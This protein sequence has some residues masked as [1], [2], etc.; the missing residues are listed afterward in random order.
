MPF[1]KPVEMHT[2]IIKTAFSDCGEPQPCFP[3]RTRPSFHFQMQAGWGQCC[4]FLHRSRSGCE[5][6]FQNRAS[7]FSIFGRR[8]FG[9]S[10]IIFFLKASKWRLKPWAWAPAGLCRAG[11][12]GVLWLCWGWC[13]TGASLWGTLGIIAFFLIEQNYCL[14]LLVSQVGMLSP[15]RMSFKKFFPPL[16]SHFAGHRVKLRGNCQLVFSENQT[17]AFN[18]S[19][20]NAGPQS[21]LAVR[22]HGLVGWQRAWELRGCESYSFSS[23]PSVKPSGSVKNF[24]SH[25]YREEPDKGGG[26]EW[27]SMKHRPEAQGGL[28]APFLLVGG[29]YPDITGQTPGSLWELCLSDQWGVLL[30]QNLVTGNGRKGT[31]VYWVLARGHD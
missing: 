14:N 15:V 13:G 25:T 2:L 20:G 3:I 7:G 22:W 17:C 21:A 10:G 29:H 4:L 23:T 30:R 12:G 31:N 28:Q 24:S 19:Q 8:T 11:V 27:G 5:E 18:I 16:F 26:S 9:V 1:I 6:S